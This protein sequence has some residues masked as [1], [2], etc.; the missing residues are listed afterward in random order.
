MMVELIV[1]R[2]AIVGGDVIMTWSSSGT[3]ESVA[4]ALWSIPDRWA[5]DYRICDAN[6]D[7]YAVEFNEDP[8]DPD[9]MIPALGGFV[10]KEVDKY[11][12][13]VK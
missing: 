12:K 11:S 1:L 5:L 7:V 6:G 10:C 4:A 9:M 13:E 3:F 2:S 8:E